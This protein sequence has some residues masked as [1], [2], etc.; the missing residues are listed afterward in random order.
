MLIA[1][2]RLDFVE[3]VFTEPAIANRN[4]LP[5]N[6]RLHKLRM[7]RPQMADFKPALEGDQG[8]QPNC[9]ERMSRS[10]IK[11]RQMRRAINPRGSHF[12]SV[13]GRMAAQ[14]SKV[15]PTD[16]SQE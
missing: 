12:P 5:A 14:V 15:Q 4:M 9:R 8:A 6:A 2:L 16:A 3:A 1:W 11:T 10:V 13:G 7:R